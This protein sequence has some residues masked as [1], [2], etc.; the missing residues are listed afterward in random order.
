MEK[1]VDSDGGHVVGVL[2]LHSAGRGALR[3]GQHDGVCSLRTDVMM[4]STVTPFLL[5]YGQCRIQ[6]LW[7][8][9]EDLLVRSASF[10]LNHR[11]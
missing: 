6:C 9:T 2:V 11:S 5:H 7:T 4:S 10:C 1:G 3:A 8:K